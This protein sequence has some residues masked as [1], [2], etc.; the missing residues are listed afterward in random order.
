MPTYW[1]S[2][3]KWIIFF[4]TYNLLRLNQEEVEN[5]SWLVTNKDIDLVIKQTN[6]QTIFQW[7]KVQDQK[8]SLVNINKY[9]NNI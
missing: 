9:S 5:L 8:A 1:T 3:K 7:T 2:L 6:K 4:E